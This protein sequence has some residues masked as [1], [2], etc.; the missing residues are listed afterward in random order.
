MAIQLTRTEVPLTTD[1][2]RMF[3]RDQPDYNILLDDVEFKDTDIH[4]AMKLTTQKW[5]AVTPVSNVTNPADLNG[6]VL[7]CGVCGFL[8]KSEG[9]RQLRNQL[10]TQ[11]GNIAPVG[12]D[13]K[14]SLYLKWAAHFQNE[15]MEKAQRIKIQQN[16]E[17][18][19]DSRT[20][21]IGSD[22]R[23]TFTKVM[24]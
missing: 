5:N 10:Q 1:E 19:F 2:I 7:L 17:S 23:Y 20:N 6:Y 4:L 21:G 14:E 16:I 13:E 12:M 9:L 8:L 18:L 3:L 11:D 15:F 24:Y 22:Y